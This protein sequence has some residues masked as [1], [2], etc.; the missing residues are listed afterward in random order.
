MSTKYQMEI[1]AFMESVKQKNGHEPEF[2][3]AVHEVAEAIIPFTE[4]NPKYKTAKIL[5]RIVEPERT[6]I[7]RVPWLDDNGNVQVNRG[8]RVEFNSAIGPYKGGLRFHPSVN[9]S[10]LK[11]LGFEQI[12]K[13]SLTTLPM[14]GGKGGSD[15]DPKGKS[16]NEVMKF[17]QSFMTE[18]CRHIGADTDVPAGD[19]GVGG[20]EIGYMFGQY[21]RI[22]NEFTGVL[23]G[24]ARNWGGSL[25][26]PEATGYGT[27]YFAKEMLATK[28]DSFLG[29]TVVISGSGNVAQFACEKATQLGAKVV[30]LSDSS[31]YIYDAEGIDAK[32]LAYVM[33]LKNVKRGRID[34]YTKQFPQSQFIAGKRPWEVKA[35]IALPCATQNEL[36]GDEASQLVAN[37]VKCV[38]E[39]ANM[40]STPEA[41]SAFQAANVLFAP[42]KASNAGGVATSGLEMSQNSLRLSW[43]AEEVDQKLHGI[44]VSIHEACVKYGT[45]SDGN[46]DYVKGANI[47]GFVKV[48]DA[49]MDQGLV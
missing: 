32:K 15:F 21:K 18:L 20:R 11:F 37:G 46:V 25:I 8:Y 26:R 14:G 22:R 3:Q 17:C 39:G 38:A 4:D 7:F 35:D 44:M 19:I 10:I 48:A 27:V 33:D 30:T 34:E 31:G 45:K 41:I 2:L 47:A 49:M 5:E 9:L 1:D 6:I 24:K 13:N 23:T 29:K 42:G 36:N 28:G 12:F 43:S 16:D 40:P